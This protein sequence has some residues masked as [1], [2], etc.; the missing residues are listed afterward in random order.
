MPGEVT[1]GAKLSITEGTAASLNL[2]M[3]CG[4]AT[5]MATLEQVKV[6]S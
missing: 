3:L 4:T 5:R 2:G 6:V 1:F